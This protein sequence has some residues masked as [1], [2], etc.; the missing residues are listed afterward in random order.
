[1]FVVVL[2]IFVFVNNVE[3]ELILGFLFIL[4]VEDEYDIVIFICDVL[5]GSFNVYLVF[6]GKEVL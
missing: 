2:F 4:V 5:S 6:N 3:E 1:M